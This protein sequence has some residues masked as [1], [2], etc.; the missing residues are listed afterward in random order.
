MNRFNNNKPNNYNYRAPKNSSCNA[1]PFNKANRH[2]LLNELIVESN[3]AVN[4]AFITEDVPDNN[5]SALLVNSTT[6]NKLNPRDIKK[7]LSISGK[8][9]SAP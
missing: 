2:E 7:I 8:G 1:K 6:A 3:G 9:Q 5:E 4:D